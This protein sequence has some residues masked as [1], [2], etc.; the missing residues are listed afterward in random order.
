MRIDNGTLMLVMTNNVVEN[1]KT[2]GL[3]GLSSLT[4]NYTEI[5]E[6][7]FKNQ[8]NNGLVYLQFHVFYNV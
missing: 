8:L 6:V 7:N 5:E 4:F 3:Q 2:G 1:H